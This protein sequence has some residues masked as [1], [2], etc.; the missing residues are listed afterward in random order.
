MSA[1]PTIPAI[2]VSHGA[3]DLILTDMPARSALMGL[4]KHFPR[5]PSAII[6]VSAHWETDAPQIMSGSNHKAMH[7]F[8]G[9]DPQLDAFEY[10]VAGAPQLAEEIKRALDAAGHRVAYDAARSLDHG[11]WVPLR[12]GFPKADIPVLQLSIQPLASPSHHFEL[13]RTLSKLRANDVLILASGGFTHNLHAY[14]RARMD[15]EETPAPWVKVFG[16]WLAAKIEAGEKDDLLAYRDIAPFARENHP[17]D[18]HLLPLFVA[19]G[20]GNAS[21]RGRALHHSTI[22]GV[23]RMDA[24]EFE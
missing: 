11:A 10:D 23:L 7:D 9:F 22:N 2:F 16:D 20:A 14:F 6:A 15:G 12:L 3:P 18:E 24:F 8:R 17:T 19:V 13:G 1:S 5:R 4:A 21:A